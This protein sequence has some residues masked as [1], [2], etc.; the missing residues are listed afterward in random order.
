MWL[1][2]IGFWHNILYIIYFPAWILTTVFC[3]Y[4]LQLLPITLD[5]SENFLNCEIPTVSSLQVDIAS[6]SNQ[7]VRMDND[8]K[9]EHYNCN[10]ILLFL[11]S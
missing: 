10:H 3:S 4:D 7:M 6:G 1:Y 5:S 11:F 2:T 9:R 8:Q